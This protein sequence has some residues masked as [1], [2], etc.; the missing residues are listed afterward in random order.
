MPGDQ[1]ITDK[2]QIPTNLRLFLIAEQV[3]KAGVPVSPSAIASALGLP[4][5]TVHRLLATAA[6]LIERL[7]W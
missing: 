2:V 7:L 6:S 3:A 1:A 4:K 5:P